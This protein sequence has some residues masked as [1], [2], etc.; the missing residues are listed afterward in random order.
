MQKR[1]PSAEELQT[2]KTTRKIK[3]FIDENWAEKN[4]EKQ[5]DFKKKKKAVTRGNR[6]RLNWLHSVPS[7]MT[8][9]M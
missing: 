4:S 2:K 5:L 1:I 9:I 6:Q 7:F 8:R 3:I